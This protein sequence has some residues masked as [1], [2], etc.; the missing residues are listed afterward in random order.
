[1][2]LHSWSSILPHCSLDKQTYFIAPSALD[3]FETAWVI[4]QL[5]KAHGH[6][7]QQVCNCPLLSV[8]GGILRLWLTAELLQ[9]L[10]ACFIVT[11]WNERVPTWLMHWDEEGGSDAAPCRW[12]KARRDQRNRMVW[13]VNLKINAQ[14]RFAARDEPQKILDEESLSLMPRFTGFFWKM[15]WIHEYDPFFLYFCHV[16]YWHI[17]NK[18]FKPTKQMSSAKLCESYTSC[19]NMTLS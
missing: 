15:C 10:G 9:V 8:S 7:L 19:S 3:V 6:N 17:K 13:D 11:A 5:P 12:T 16:S 2:I 14:G 4:W 18:K 1:M